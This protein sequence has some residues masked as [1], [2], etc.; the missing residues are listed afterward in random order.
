MR[1]KKKKFQNLAEAIS[2]S[3][4]KIGITQRELSRRTGIDNNTIAKIEKGE[5]KK[6]NILSLKKLGYALKINPDEL[7]KLAGYTEEEIEISNN[8][9]GAN[10]YMHGND[11][12]II[13][14]KE[15]I[16]AKNKKYSAYP[17]LI[18]LINN[19]NVKEI[20]FLKN[21]TDK[22]LEKINEGLKLIREDLVNELEKRSMKGENENGNK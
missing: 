21:S 14:V 3:R 8:T 22:E 19:C 15:V 10:M 11:N 4:E 2:N 17:V 16:M 1:I 13:L 5:R 7:L 20:A 9:L 6:P 12:E 18:E